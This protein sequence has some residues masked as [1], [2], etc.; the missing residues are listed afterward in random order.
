[1]E[2]CKQTYYRPKLETWYNTSFPDSRYIRIMLTSI[3][4]NTCKMPITMEVPL[5]WM[6]FSPQEVVLWTISLVIKSTVQIIICPCT[7]NSTTINISNTSRC[8]TSTAEIDHQ[9]ITGL[10]L[11][12]GLLMKWCKVVSLEVW[13]QFLHKVLS[14]FH[15]HKLKDWM[16]EIALMWQT[17]IKCKVKALLLD[18]IIS[19]WWQGRVYLSWKDRWIEKWVYKIKSKAYLSVSMTTIFLVQ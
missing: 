18:H 19:T 2:S 4:T 11:D 9:A 12:L 7:S 1:M 14:I 17:K 16:A 15:K 13:L 10:I 6:V 8:R 3:S 5:P